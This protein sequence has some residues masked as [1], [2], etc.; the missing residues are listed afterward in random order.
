MK[1]KCVFRMMT[2]GLIALAVAAYSVSL[3]AQNGGALKVT[4]FPSGA[5]VSIDGVDTGKVTPMSLSLAVGDHAVIVSIP[6]SGWNP[7][8]RIVTIVSGNNDLS[9]TLLPAV[10]AGP[11]GPPG[12]KGDTGATGP[13]G[14]AGTVTRAAGPCFDNSNRYVDCGNGTVT[15]TVTGLIW[16]KQADCLGANN[17]AVA[18]QAVVGLENGDC[19]LSDNSSPGDWRLPTKDEWSATVAHASALG[20]ALG[21][22]HL[23]NDGGK[24]CYDTG[25]GSSLAGVAP[26]LY[27]S[28]NANETEPGGAAYVNLYS[29]AVDDGSHEGKSRIHRAWPVRGGVR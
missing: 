7:D 8:S 28:S 29:G 5:K 11:P 26:D 4:S 25:V 10:T 24:G 14:A 23:T 6:N 22:P 20:C 1:T 12:P 21:T 3:G 16:L 2:V 13:T 19:G 27:W 18:N 9:V 15:D 17:W